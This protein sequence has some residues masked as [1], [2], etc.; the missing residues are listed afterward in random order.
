MRKIGIMLALGTMV[1]TSGCAVHSGPIS[2]YYASPYYTGGV[3]TYYVAPPVY[4]GPMIRY[5]YPRHYHGGRH[6]Y[7]HR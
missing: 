3:S 7:R 6:G 5:S 4:V 2:P 1:S